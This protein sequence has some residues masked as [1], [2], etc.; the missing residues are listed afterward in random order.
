MVFGDRYNKKWLHIML[1]LWV[2]QQR[3]QVYVITC[4]KSVEGNS[5]LNRTTKIMKL[6]IFCIYR[7]Y[8]LKE[9]I[10]LIFIAPYQTNAFNNGII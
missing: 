2:L 5:L 9:N 8:D 6:I 1:E 7:N 3:W 4:K 10:F